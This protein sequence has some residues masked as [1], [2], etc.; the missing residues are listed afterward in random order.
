[1][2]IA[3]DPG[4]TASAWATMSGTHMDAIGLE[5]NEHLLALLQARS[6][7]PDTLVIEMVASYGMPVG[8]EVFETCVWIGRFI[9]A[10]R[11]AWS[12]V[13]RREVKSWL[14]QDSRAKDSNVRRAILDMYPPAGG[15]KT[16]QVGT[17]A[18][19]G[20]LYGVSKDVWSAIGVGLTYQKIDPHACSIAAQGQGTLEKQ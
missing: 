2:I 15:G 4:T 1:M 8:R 19:P 16:P 10:W 7:L 3:I 13:Y 9:E 20:P 14:C 17:K 11:G 6:G 12:F 5:N 18:H